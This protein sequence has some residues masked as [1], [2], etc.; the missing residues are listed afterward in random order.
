MPRPRQYTVHGPFEVPLIKGTGG[1]LVD[2][3]RDKLQAFWKEVGEHKS[4]KGVYVFGIFFG[5]AW[6]PWYVGKTGRQTF[7]GEVF[8]VN[9]INK[10]NRAIVKDARGTPVI[11]LIAHPRTQGPIATN[12][13]TNVERFF[14]R[15]AYTK[16][17]NLLNER[18]LPTA[19]DWA[20]KGVIRS[21]QGAP[22]DAARKL[23][24]M[25]GL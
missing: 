11:F 22:P 20:V 1:R 7:E 6:T 14:I 9:N 12:Q 18:N 17:P 13:I 21:G 4:L 25:I 10:Y 2:N 8:N 16:N 5:R 19:D 23:K 15:L 3:N 24:R